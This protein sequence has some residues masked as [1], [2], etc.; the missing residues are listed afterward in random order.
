VKRRL[1]PILAFIAVVLWPQSGHSQITAFTGLQPETPTDPQSTLQII[2]PESVSPG[3]PVVVSMMGR[4]PQSRVTIRRVDG[5]TIAEAATFVMT[6]TPQFRITCAILGVSTTAEPGAYLMEIFSD[7]GDAVAS[8]PLTVDAREYRREEIALTSSLTEL[9]EREDPQK[10]AEALH[11]QA[12][13]GEFNEQSIHHTGPFVWPIP[14]TRRTSLFGDRRTYLYADGE[15]AFTV[16]LGLDLASPTG[17]AIGAAGSGRVRI[18]RGRI[19]T[20]NSVIVEHLP[21]VFSIYY[22]LDTLTVAEGEMVRA[23]DIIGTVGATGL[24]TGPHLHWEFRIG[25]VSVD[26]EKILPG[27]LVDFDR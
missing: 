9:R 4:G 18:A 6:L 21:G 14:L 22:H 24:A 2:A 11:L 8:R 25:G 19:V 7:V 20:G 12:I 27:L 15:R 16:H 13:V 23:G 10:V 5:E 26:P 3:E 1:L 17:T